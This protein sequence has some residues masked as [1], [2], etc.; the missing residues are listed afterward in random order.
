MKLNDLLKLGGVLMVVAALSATLLGFSNSYTDPI[1][2]ERR[3]EQLENS[4]FEFFPEAEEFI[5]DEID[6]QEYYVV[7][8]EGEV[9]GVA[10]VVDPGGYGGRIEMMVAADAEG[11]VSGV[12]ILSHAE[13]PGLGS[14]IEEPEWL[15]QFIG[16]SASQDI[17]G[18]E[19]VD[20]ISGATVSS[21]AVIEGVE[22]ALD[23][24][25]EDY[26]GN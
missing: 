9:S 3:M 16:L 11:T 4:M 13:T 2:Q 24:I 1:I 18:E 19:K 10:T 12:D 21:E 20:I 7:K 25:V 15:Q 22:L 17:M 14:E 5:I 6:E 8:T 23:N 26:L